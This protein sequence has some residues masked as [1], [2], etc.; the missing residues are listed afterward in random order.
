LERVRKEIAHSATLADFHRKLEAPA[1]D[2][3]TYSVSYAA[4][5][6]YHYDRVPP[7]DYMARVCAVFPELRLEWLLTGRDE[8]TRAEQRRTVASD[9]PTDWVRAL[10]WQIPALSDFPQ[11]VVVAFLHHVDLW[12]RARGILGDPAGWEDY[13]RS[14]WDHIAAPLQG[15]RPYDFV[16]FAEYVIAALHARNLALLLDT[17]SNE[18][19]RAAPLEMNVP[20]SDT[21]PKRGQPKGSKRPRSAKPRRRKP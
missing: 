5:R 17:Y 11:S 10:R 15:R 14:V 1:A 21:A 19:R 7:A 3:S 16:A 13:A 9:D 18:E 2:G 8:M 20:P 12:S 4:V 6:R